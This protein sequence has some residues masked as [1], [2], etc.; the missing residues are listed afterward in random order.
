MQTEN[1]QTEKQLNEVNVPPEQILEKHKD[2]IIKEANDLPNE[3]KML[4]N[5]LVY[6]GIYLDVDE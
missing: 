4:I 6:S 5:Y 2:E 3:L 1:T